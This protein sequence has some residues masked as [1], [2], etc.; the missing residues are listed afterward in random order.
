MGRVAFVV[1]N[2]Q[3]STR[4]GAPLQEDLWT[5]YSDRPCNSFYV[6]RHAPSTRAGPE[7][8]LKKSQS[9][10]LSREEHL[11]FPLLPHCSNPLSPAS[12]RCYMIEI[13]IDYSRPAGSPSSMTIPV[14]QK[15]ASPKGARVLV[16]GGSSGIGQAAARSGDAGAFG[17]FEPASVAGDLLV[18]RAILDRTPPNP[19]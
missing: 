15:T 12:G 5:I 4:Y 6:P 13:A 17:F 14:E 1:T 19:E 8:V 11:G 10:T 7:S 18:R 3:K 9:E 2:L 16:V